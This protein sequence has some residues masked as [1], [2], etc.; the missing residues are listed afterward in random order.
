MPEL[1]EMET[2]RSLLLQTVVNQRVTVA[3]VQREKSINVPVTEF[4]RRVEGRRIGNI[5]R[6]GKHILFWLDSQDILLLHLMLGGWMYY[7]TMADKPDH[8]SQVDLTLENDHTL[9]FLG[10]RLGYLHVIDMPSLTERLRDMGPEPLD[11]A[12]T[13]DDLR[14]ALTHKRGSLKSALTDQHCISG[15]G[16]RYSD[17]IFASR[18]VF[19]H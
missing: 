10:L 2:Y 13:A 14:T 17:E 3:H 12:F 8:D 16:N 6:R 11:P 4:K 15:I 9:F 19:S 7:G 1:P 5:T 18:P